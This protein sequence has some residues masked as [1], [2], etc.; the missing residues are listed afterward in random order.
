MSSST[1]SSAAA[2]GNAS[3]GIADFKINHFAYISSLPRDPHTPSVAETPEHVMR[4]ARSVPKAA[5]S[6][7]VPELPPNP[8]LEC[9]S[10][11]ALRFLGLNAPD[12]DFTLKA[13]SESDRQL[14][15]KYFSGA[16]GVPDAQPWAHMYA[17][18]QFG[19]FAGQLGDGRAISL[20]QVKNQQG[21]MW[22]VQLKG[23]GNTP[24]SRFGDGFAVLRSSIREFLCSEHFAALGIPTSR[25]ATLI[26]TGQLVHREQLEPGA[27]VA[28]LAPSWIRFGSFEGFA[29]RGDIANLAKLIDYTA[30]NVLPSTLTNSVTLGHPDSTPSVTVRMYAEA[31]RRT[32]ETVAMW[33]LVAWEHGVLN[34]DNMS[35]LGLTI[36]YGPFGFLDHY[37]P[38]Y[39]VNHS[40]STGRYTLRNQ[41]DIGMWNLAKLANSLVEIVGHELVYNMSL[42]ELAEMTAEG[43]ADTQ[44][45]QEAS[46]RGRQPLVDEIM[47][48]GEIYSQVYNDG[49]RKKLGLRTSDSTDEEH[50]IKPLLAVL[51]Q[52]QVDWTRF[53]RNLCHLDP[54]NPPAP[55]LSDAVEPLVLRASQVAESASGEACAM[56]VSSLGDKKTEDDGG[57]HSLN[58]VKPPPPMDQVRDAYRKWR[59][60]YLARVKSEMD[61]GSGFAN[62]EERIRAMRAVNPKF[63][64]R[65]WIAQ[66]TIDAAE[67]EN[68]REAVARALCVLSDP[69]AEVP[70]GVEQFQNLPSRWW[71]AWAEE[72]P[73]WGKGIVCSCSS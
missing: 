11:P 35:I 2:S 53:W 4:Q 73:A 21:D 26:R 59:T 33:D 32:A 23:A 67:K 40:D 15:G 29:F 42:K 28:R 17:G 55:N 16:T 6:F 63:V 25:A 71:D 13:W 5:Y 45:R 10:P 68:D 31:V 51:E 3:S 43:L 44:A 41:R 69:F 7:V 20:G 37:D 52:G 70:R 34:T 57:D 24:Y 61:G 38:D 56:P 47:K 39:I 60:T 50:I 66:A 36:D 62:Q 9:V 64:L 49:M 18:H 48:Y 30:T 8:E 58:P 1:S 22:E 46:K 12:V 27:I 54:F 14:L 65:Q 72:P 19:S